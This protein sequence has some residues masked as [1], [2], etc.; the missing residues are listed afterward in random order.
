M[1]DRLQASGSPNV[2]SQGSGMHLTEDGERIFSGN[3]IALLP[4]GREPVLTEPLQELLSEL[5]LEPGKTFED[6]K[7]LPASAFP[8]RL[9]DRIYLCTCCA[10]DPAV[11]IMIVLRTAE[12]TDLACFLR[13][14]F[15]TSPS[16]MLMLIDADGTV[17]ASTRATDEFLGVS[18]VGSALSEHID[19]ASTLAFSTFLQSAGASGEGGGETARSTLLLDFRARGSG[20][21]DSML[22]GIGRAPGPDP[23]FVVALEP[24]PESGRASTAEA[25]RDET[26]SMMNLMP[27]PAILLDKVGMVTM[28]N[29]AAVSLALEVTGRRPRGTHFEEWLHP[30]CRDEVAGMFRSRMEGRYAPES[31][32]ALLSIDGSDPVEMTVRAHLMPSGEEVL[33]FLIPPSE[34]L[35]DGSFLGVEVLCERLS[36]ILRDYTRSESPEK[37]LVR[38]VRSGL[39]AQGVALTRADLTTTEGDIPVSAGTGTGAGS[40]SPSSGAFTMQRNR[41]GLWDITL[42]I[43]SVTGSSGSPAV[44]RVF[45]RAVEELGPLERLLLDL[46]PVLVDQQASRKAIRS[47]MRSFFSITESAEELTRNQ[48]TL[49]DF[50]RRLAPALDA[51]HFLVTRISPGRE[52][53]IPVSGFGFPEQAPSFRVREESLQSWVYKHGEPLYVPDCEVDSRFRLISPEARSEICSPIWARGTACG[54][55]SAASMKPECFTNHDLSMLR[56]FS[57]LS[58]LWLGYTGSADPGVR[59]GTGTRGDAPDTPSPIG[60]DLYAA[61]SQDVLAPLSTILGYSG[62]LRDGSLGELGEEQRNTARTIAESASTLGRRVNALFSLVETCVAPDSTGTAWGRPAE[63]VSRVV[64]GFRDEADRCGVR[65][66]IENADESL[67]ASFDPDHLSQ[68]LSSLLDNAIR[69]GGDGDGEVRICVEADGESHWKLEV[70]DDGPGIPAESLPRVFERLYRTPDR[71]GRTGTGLGLTLVRKLSELHGGTVS[72][73]NTAGKGATFTVRFPTGG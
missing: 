22:C 4:P 1:P 25:S 43:T 6:L 61:V 41:D 14:S 50:L 21:I 19:P 23:L 13:D 65:L 38:L 24:A 55:I 64:E 34:S 40:V 69:F 59:T 28:A 10:L 44:L 53:L 73:L 27:I 66:L 51:D 60:R 15:S 31:H 58:S 49:R 35:D 2:R 52:E 47:A 32:R 62:M 30:E 26:V 9:G 29:G 36:S 33:V 11:G 72:V 17:M 12:E 18:P 46:V 7:N 3:L 20:R 63:V 16:G 70:S 68:I 39:N 37:D 56:F 8:L 42:D 54:A 57:V 45:G 71:W 67:A 48:I 5:R